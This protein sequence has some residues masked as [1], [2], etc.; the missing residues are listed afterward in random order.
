MRDFSASP[1]LFSAAKGRADLTPSGPGELE[2]TAQRL[3]QNGVTDTVLLDLFCSLARAQ[4]WVLANRGGSVVDSARTPI[5]T[6]ASCVARCCSSHLLEASP[7]RSTPLLWRRP[8]VRSLLPAA[9]SRRPRQRRASSVSR[10]SFAPLRKQCAGLHDETSVRQ[11][12]W[13]TEYYERIQDLAKRI[14]TWSVSRAKEGKREY[15]ISTVRN[16]RPHQHT[17]SP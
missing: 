9:R 1:D 15:A 12:K 11:G 7:R 3:Q 16:S 8:T 13:V 5:L 2:E 6:Q 17:A 14:S 10:R 4:C